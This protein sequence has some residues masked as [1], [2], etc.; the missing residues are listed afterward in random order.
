MTE[1]VKPTKAESFAFLSKNTSLAQDFLAAYFWYASQGAGK[2]ACGYA[3]VRVAKDYGMTAK[4]VVRK[5][6][7]CGLVGKVYDNSPFSQTIPIVS[8][9]NHNSP[10]GLTMEE[11]KKRAASVIRRYLGDNLA[12][13]LFDKEFERDLVKKPTATVPPKPVPKPAEVR[14]IVPANP[15]INVDLSVVQKLASDVGEVAITTKDGYT[16]VFSNGSNK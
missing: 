16:I 3:D 15:T 12:P 1:I 8:E 11:A 9:M 14:P 10:A 5:R 2:N 13:S 7:K 4:E 6:E